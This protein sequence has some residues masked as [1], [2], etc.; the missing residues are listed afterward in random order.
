MSMRTDRMIFKAIT[1][2]FLLV[3]SAGCAETNIGVKDA[4]QPAMSDT[5]VIQA[6]KVSSDASQVEISADKRLTFTF[7]KST[8]PPMAV[9]DLA[10]TEPGAVTR[11]IAVNSGIIRDIH[12]SSHSVG[13]GV[14]SR[15]EIA[16]TKDAEFTVTPDPVDKA[17]LLVTF[18]K[19]QAAAAATVN[20]EGKAE[21]KE[22]AQPEAV[23]SAPPAAAAELRIKPEDGGAKPEAA[24]KEKGITAS[25]IKESDAS[26]MASSTNPAPAPAVTTKRE[27]IAAGV[28]AKDAIKPGQRVLT[29]INVVKDGVEL[30]VNGGVE[31]FNA[32]KLTKPTRLVVDIIGAKSGIAAKVIPVNSFG[33]AK[34]RLGTTADKVRIVFDSSKEALPAYKVTKYDKGVKVDFAGVPIT[35]SAKAA[36]TTKGSS[37]ALPAPESRSAGKGRTGIVEA[38][39]FKLVDGYSRIAIKVSGDCIVGKPVKTAEG[40]ALTIKKC[41]IPAN[42]QRMLDTRAFASVVTAVTPYQIRMKKGY[43]SR[44]L[45]RLRADAPYKIN[46]EGDTIFWDI[47]NP[48]GM[49]TPSLMSEVAKPP[50]PRPVAVKPGK[51]EMI[52]TAASKAAQKKTYTGRRVS[53]EFSDAD[54]RKIFQ[55]IAEV[56][57]LNFLIADD[58]SGTI[59]LKLINVPWDQALDVILE[60]KNLEKKQE[61]NIMY[62]RPK[63]RFKTQ[64]QE[65][66]EA[67]KLRERTMPLK[68]QVFDVNFAAIGDVAGQFNTL[69]SERG[70]IIQDAR[71][72]KVIVTDIEPKLQAMKDLLKILDVPEKQVMIEARIVEATSTFV[73]DLGV[74][75]GIHYNDGSASILGINKL[76]TGFGGVVSAP[77]ASGLPTVDSSGGA[78]GLSFGTLTSNVQVDLRLSAA[79]TAG[80]I[81]I[82]STPK[83]VTLNNKAA[84][85]TQGQSI[86][87]QTTSA[88]GT[89]TE[90]V[91]AALTLEVT[92]H[93]TADGNIGMKVHASNNSAGT[94]NPPPINTKEA[95]TELQVRN[96]ETTVIG[97]IYVDS[98]TE[99]DQGVPFLMNIP[100]L[101]WLFKSNTVNKTK[102]E[103]LIFI[104]PKI[105]S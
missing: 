75:W 95:T 20:A 103:L 44:F 47:K 59:S 86:P 52:D 62:I 76:D 1:L 49:E 38:L 78:L 26:P 90:F 8:E 14:L 89:K 42:L 56:S 6:V 79:A 94:G 27:E 55:L 18:P 61:G 53:L 12:I 25:E 4:S 48:E 5:S 51:T 7:Y 71:T 72:N 45:V 10:Q 104:T 65:D 99:S 83:V 19:T 58:V 9:I 57:N 66:A 74:Q 15:I 32:F 101:G 30:E 102:T 67:Q 34:A 91:Q 98:D 87:Y 70:K 43:D 40:L 105:V 82:V 50:V 3:V 21:V 28:E 39:D 54:I 92:P 80:L 13:G 69:A 93:I 17:K 97:G 33:I 81:K 16:L 85:I 22:T 35:S 31:S 29:A 36:P 23:K 73:R 46:Q 60:S 63:G 96:G 37:Q 84:K 41:Q 77:P 2:L 68:T 11:Q 24:I 100:L 88:E 64:E